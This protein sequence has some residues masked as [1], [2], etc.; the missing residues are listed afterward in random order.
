MKIAQLSKRMSLLGPDTLSILALA[1]PAQSLGKHRELLDDLRKQR[2][3]RYCHSILLFVRSNECYAAIMRDELILVA[4]RLF[5]EHGYDSVST[6][7]LA[8]EAGTMMSSITYHFGGKLGLYQAAGQ[9]ILD[10]L[11]AAMEER[12]IAPLQPTAGAEEA[13]DLIEQVIGNMGA[14]MLQED[15]TPMARFVVREHNDPNSEIGN[16]LRLEVQR[17]GQMM[18]DAIAILRPDLSAEQC[19]SRA[20][21]IYAMITGLQNARAPLSA[22]TG[23]AAIDHEQGE[24]LLGNL[25]QA[26]RDMLIRP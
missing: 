19:R 1:G 12:P 20:F 26:A 5:G 8:S 17:V 18:A 2:T 10:R 3:K 7:R 14:F 21:Y 24:R 13:I 23:W 22:I 4:I 6:R 11:N 9:A 15:I 25:K 16:K